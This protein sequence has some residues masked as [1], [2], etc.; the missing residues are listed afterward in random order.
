M[1]TATAPTIKETI[2]IIEC[3]A[4]VS[5]RSKFVYDLVIVRW[6]WCANFCCVACSL[7]SH[8][9][10]FRCL[11]SGDVDYVLLCCLVYWNN[12]KV[13]IL[14]RQY[15]FHIASWYRTSIRLS[16]CIRYQWM[17]RGT[18]VTVRLPPNWS[19]LNPNRTSKHMLNVYLFEISYFYFISY[20]A[21]YLF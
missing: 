4:N 20:G 18:I 12:F 8:R 14:V 10:T 19:T 3:C 16:V 15:I 21:K 6:R 5:I 1:A 11:L 17:D 7:D 2:R 9:I 13:H